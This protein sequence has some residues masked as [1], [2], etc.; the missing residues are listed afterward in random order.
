M[1]E[2]QIENSLSEHAR[3]LVKWC[4]QANWLNMHSALVK[5][6]EGNSLTPEVCYHHSNTRMLSLLH[7]IT[8]HPRFRIASSALMLS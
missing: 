3:K 2:Q 8:Q 4:R 5:T 1:S 6:F 7:S